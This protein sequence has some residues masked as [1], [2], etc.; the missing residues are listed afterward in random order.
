MVFPI[1]LVQGVYG[2][3]WKDGAKNLTGK[4]SRLT[5]GFKTCLKISKSSP[6][7]ARVNT[8]T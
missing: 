4:V 8:A 6:I 3:I 1:N 5:L 2:G 7:G